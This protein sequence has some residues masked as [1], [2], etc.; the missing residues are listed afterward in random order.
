MANKLTQKSLTEATRS[1]DKVSGGDGMAVTHMRQHVTMQSPPSGPI[2]IPGS[3]VVAFAFVEEFDNWIT[4]K[5]YS[6]ATGEQ[7]ETLTYIAKPLHLRRDQYEIFDESDPPEQ[8]PIAYP[9]GTE[10]LYEFVAVNERKCTDTNDDDGYYENQK[11]TPP[12]Y[13]GEIFYAMTAQTGL[14]NDD[15]ATIVWVEVSP[16]VWARSN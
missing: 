3:S 2:A 5:R 4:A 14:K 16:R 13:V 6:W 11:I 10:Y 7:S 9:D 1:N 8:Q 12:Y 15:D